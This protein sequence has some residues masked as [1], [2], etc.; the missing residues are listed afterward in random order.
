MQHIFFRV[1][2]ISMLIQ[3]YETFPK[4]PDGNVEKYIYTRCS[5]WLPN[6]KRCQ[7][8]HYK[9][10][11]ISLSRI[12]FAWAYPAKNRWIIIEKILDFI[13]F[14]VFNCTLYILLWQVC[15]FSLKLVKNEGNNNLVFPA[16][17]MY[18]NNQVSCTLYTS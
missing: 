7:L 5:E 15:V 1:Q 13:P 10:L 17:Y 2:T 14:I 18:K 4:H 6:D 9:S 12:L 8:S 16:V 3:Y 11:L